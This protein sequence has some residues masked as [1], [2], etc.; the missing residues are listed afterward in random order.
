MAGGASANP[1]NLSSTPVGTQGATTSAYTPRF[2]ALPTAPTTSAP[3]TTYSLS[4]TPRQGFAQQG[5]PYQPFAS[6]MPAQVTGYGNF[7]QAPTSVNRGPSADQVRAQ[8]LAYQQQYQPG[9]Q[10]AQR[11]V[12]QY[13][14]QMRQAEENRKAEIARRAAEAAAAA[15]AARLA[16]EERLRQE[17]A[18]Q[19]SGNGDQFAGASGGLASLRGFE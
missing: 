8:M 4:T 18:A 19:S 1:S 11:D 14:V 15:E 12:Q 5:A 16:E 3:G 13:N 2:A 9:M 7:P 17:Q 6:R 10:R